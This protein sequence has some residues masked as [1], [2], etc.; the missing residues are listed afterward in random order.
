MPALTPH[1]ERPFI[2]GAFEGRYWIE[3][4][5][6]K[7]EWGKKMFPKKQTNK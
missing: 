5:P 6:W 4:L 7:F 1:F 2:Q 3:I